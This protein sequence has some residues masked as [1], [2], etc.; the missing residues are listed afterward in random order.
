M[1]G[2]ID[3]NSSKQCKNTF[4]IKGEQ[5]MT[6]IRFY[7]V[8][9]LFLIGGSYSDTVLA[10][11]RG[12]AGPADVISQTLQFEAH[13]LEI[14]AVGTAEA[15]RSVNIFPA[16]ADKVVAVNFVPG[17]K[18]EKGMMLLALDARRQRTALE[19]AKIQ[20]QDA[21]RTLT[22]LKQ[23][24]QRGAVTQSVLDDAATAQ[25]LA[26]VQL[27]EANDDLDDR[28]VIAPFTGVVGLTDVEVGDR[29]GINTLITT[30][31]MREKLFINFSAPE[32]ALSL[33]LRDSQVTVQPWTDRNLT[34]PAEVAELDSRVAETDRTIRAR[35]LLANDEDVYRPGMSFRVN[36][37]FYGQRYAVIPESG[38]S[39]G[40]TGSYIWLVQKNKAKKVAVDIKQRLRGKILVSGEVSEGDELI[41]EGIQQLRDGQEVASK[42]ELATR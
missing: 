19:R 4:L 8:I 3:R 26:E 23:S 5:C 16:A 36:L 40:A 32:S 34:L 30:I 24:K 7:H 33:L 28:T 21:S 12:G 25:A 20:L 27:A 9:F 35:A 10:Q 37:S 15:F 13:K 17:Q 6:T 38:L 41:V 31:D 22:R 42:A 1:Q 39:W 14:E 29:I 18:V 2:L 11:S